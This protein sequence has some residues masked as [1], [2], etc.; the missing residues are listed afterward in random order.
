MNNLNSGLRVLLVTS[1][2]LSSSPFSYAAAAAAAKKK[3]SMRVGGVSVKR[4]SEKP[5]PH[6]KQIKLPHST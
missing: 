3:K 2:K 5:L 4:L 6:V 1:F